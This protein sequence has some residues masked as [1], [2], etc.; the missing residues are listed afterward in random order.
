MRP[1]A[2]GGAGG[3]FGAA[4]RFA[5][6]RRVVFRAAFLRAL[7]GGFLPAVF[8]AAFFLAGIRSSLSMP[9]PSGAAHAN[10]ESL[11]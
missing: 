1:I 9:A 11:S 10:D 4:G 7:L 8:R 5:D 6:G 2:L 3:A